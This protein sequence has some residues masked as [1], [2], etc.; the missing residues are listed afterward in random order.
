MVRINSA[1]RRIPSLVPFI[2]VLLW[3]AV[4]VATVLRVVPL[5]ESPMLPGVPWEDSNGNMLDFRSLIW[6]PGHVLLAGGNPYDPD[7][8]LGTF[9][10]TE[11][12]DPYAPVWLLISAALAPLPYLVG[13]AV[14]QVLNI[15]LAVV[16]LWILLRRTMPSVVVVALPA[17]LL[18]MNLWFPGRGALQSGSNLVVMLGVVLALRALLNNRDSQ[19]SNVDD[20]WG[21]VGLALSLV[22]PQFGF[23]V[24]LAVLAERRWR[25][26]W[27]GIATLFVAS[28]P[29]LI[30]CVISAGGVVGFAESI[31]RDL[32]RA[33]SL[34]SAA[35]LHSPV[36]RR[37]DFL[38]LL[39]RNGVEPPTWVQ[40]AVPLVAVALVVVLVL[41]ARRPIGVATAVCALALL[42]LV[43]QPSDL[44]LA[45]VPLAVGLGVLVQHR[46]VVISDGVILAAWVV[47]VLHIHRVSTTLVPGLGE[48]GADMIDSVA[49]LI[50]LGG[51]VASMWQTSTNRAE[52]K[53]S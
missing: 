19:S 28:L 34:D 31:G 24:L 23:A 29:A 3:H 5:F 47:I 45:V 43:H 41:R 8:L 25:M 53:V 1:S 51:A 50:A 13:A 26:L 39:A 27:R 20:W 44:V 52:L 16:I 46:T 9:P 48:R 21:A 35:G 49:L 38:G 14:Y 40:A 4:A 10:W 22:K 7:S 2:A 11:E 36:S 6:A 12:F 42:G 18:W 37:V 15:A 32:A 17:A 33:S 30:A